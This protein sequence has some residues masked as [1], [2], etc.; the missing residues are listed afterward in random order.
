MLASLRSFAPPSVRSM[1][2]LRLTLG[3][4]LVFGAGAQAQ[5]VF[6][7]APVT[8]EVVARDEQGRTTV[9]ATRLT[10]WTA[11]STRRYTSP[12]S[13]LRTSFSRYRMRAPPEVSARKSG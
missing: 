7:P 2:S 10:A 3:L 12:C 4:T 1:S 6:P 5:E 13:R 11:G 8:P 9:R